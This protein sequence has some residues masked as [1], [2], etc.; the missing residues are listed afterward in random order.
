MY[1]ILDYIIFLNKSQYINI[2]TNKYKGY[3]DFRY[4]L[5]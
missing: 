1:A 2:L 4:F 5:V 3:F